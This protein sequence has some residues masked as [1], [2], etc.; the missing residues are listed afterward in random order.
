MVPLFIVVRHRRVRGRCKR[1]RFLI[2]RNSDRRQMSAH[3]RSD[4]GRYVFNATWRGRPV[5]SIE[6][7]QRKDS[8][9]KPTQPRQSH[10]VR[11]ARG[12]AHCQVESAARLER[13]MPMPASTVAPTTPLPEP[14]RVPNEGGG[15]ARQ[16]HEAKTSRRFIRRAWTQRRQVPWNGPREQRR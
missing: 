5:G 7:K 8:A 1:H 12:N 6:S 9:R 15:P 13:Q 11:A 10:P 4:S 14:P 3:A 16:E 2:R